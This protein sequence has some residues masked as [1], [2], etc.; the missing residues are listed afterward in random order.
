MKNGSWRLIANSE[1][2]QRCLSKAQTAMD[3]VVLHDL[4]V[5]SGTLLFCTGYICAT[6]L[7]VRLG[8]L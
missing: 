1:K 7:L 4:Q 8:V 6:A 2:A 5:L 3:C